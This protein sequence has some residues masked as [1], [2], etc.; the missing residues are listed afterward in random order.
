MLTILIIN[1]FPLDH[2]H[3]IDSLILL[4]ENPIALLAN[5]QAL[6]SLMHFS[7]PKAES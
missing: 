1:C 6:S 7:L 2:V 5:I 4:S 3:L